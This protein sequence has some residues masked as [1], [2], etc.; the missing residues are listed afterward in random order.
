MQVLLLLLKF[1]STHG[2]VPDR[3]QSP[4]PQ[5]TNPSHRKSHEG[6]QIKTETWEMNYQSA[7]VSEDSSS[8]V[9]GT[10]TARVLPGTMCPA[11]L[12]VS[13][14]SGQG[15]PTHSTSS[16]GLTSSESSKTT[17]SHISVYWPHI[18]EEEIIWSTSPSP[19][20]L[21]FVSYQYCESF[22]MK[23]LSSIDTVTKD[24]KGRRKERR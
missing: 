6:T 21:G 18:L 5:Y 1:S 4:L 13:P 7:K 16:Q 11:V 14:A 20:L 22:P 10:Q 12:L 24:N 8:W 2:Q 15:I 9:H 17:F 3:A 23:L 19:H